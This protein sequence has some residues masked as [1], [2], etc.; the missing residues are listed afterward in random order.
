MVEA[1]PCMKKFV[2]SVNRATVKFSIIAFDS[3]PIYCPQVAASLLIADAGFRVPFPSGREHGIAP[4]RT[5][6]KPGSGS[7]WKQL[8]SMIFRKFLYQQAK[9]KPVISG[10]VRQVRNKVKGRKDKNSTEQVVRNTKSR[11][12]ARR[13]KNS[14][15]WFPSCHWQIAQRKTWWD[16]TKSGYKL[17]REFVILKI[18]E[19]GWFWRDAA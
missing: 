11:K 4:D 3:L 12:Q 19:Q 16:F 14:G 2:H 1:L 7:L 17:K 9:I 15:Y 13:E 8:E 10:F 18:T 5:Y 6:K